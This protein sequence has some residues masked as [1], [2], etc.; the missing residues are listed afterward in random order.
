MHKTAD[1]LDA[2]LA[3]SR[4]MIQDNMRDS[5]AWLIRGLICI[6]E[7]Q[8]A[9]EQ[10]TE[11]T[12]ED[13]GVGFSG[14]DGQIMTSFAKQVLRHQADPSPRFKDP[15][16]PRQLE[17]VRRKMHKYAMQLA[18]IARAKRDAERQRVAAETEAGLTA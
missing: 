16:S 18:R 4:V 9:E 12:R 5:D 13:N 10:N 3:N 11:T 1:I 6:F 15:L 7:R 8:T 17:I 14:L 2:S